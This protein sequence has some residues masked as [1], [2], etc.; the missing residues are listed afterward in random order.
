MKPV[1]AIQWNSGPLKGHFCQGKVS[2]ISIYGPLNN[3]PYMKFQ[4]FLKITHAITLS[5]PP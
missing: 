5:Y 1:A 4:I 3:P 2:N